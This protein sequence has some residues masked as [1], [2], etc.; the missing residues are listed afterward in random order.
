MLTTATGRAAAALVNVVA[1][2]A[3]LSGLSLNIAAAAFGGALIGVGQWLVLRQRLSDASRWVAASAA[4]YAVGAVLIYSLLSNR[5]VFRLDPTTLSI[6]QSAVSGISLGVMQWLVLRPHAVG[7][8]WW[9]P[10]SAAGGI[11]SGAVVRIGAVPFEI[12]PVAA[13]GVLSG[14][15][16]GGITGAALV[17]MLQRPIP[18]DLERA[19]AQPPAAVGAGFWPA[20]I[21]ATAAGFAVGFNLVQAVS[22][23]VGGT[24]LIAIGVAAGISVGLPVGVAQWL[25]LRGKINAPGWWVPA[26]VAGWAVGVPVGLGA[27]FLPL[28]PGWGPTTG[29]LS[30][31]AAIGLLAGAMQW[32]ILRQHVR[33][34]GWWVLASA[35][36]WA[37]GL[38]FGVDLLNASALSNFGFDTY[39]MIT[40]IGGL[41]GA[42]AGTVSGLALTWL[43]RQPKHVNG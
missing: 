30:L 21:V 35:T 31:G 23:T 39:E 37:A 40:V 13:I 12:A 22:L 4:G 18:A 25:A 26:S 2:R 8:A 36:S 34:A 29:V 43:L 15:L 28:T 6:I 41:I 14:A 10:A 3:A 42:V 7:A 5:L 38:Y 16:F 11:V 32:L 9:I 20:W 19:L 17:W 27:M 1:V 33:G 24:D